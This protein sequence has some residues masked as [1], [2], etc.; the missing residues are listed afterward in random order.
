MRSTI[1]FLLS[2]PILF[3]CSGQDELSDSPGNPEEIPAGVSKVV[4]RSNAQASR[5]VYIFRKEGDEFRYNS[6]I[7]NGW[8]ADGQMTTRLLLGDYKFLFTLP[9]GEGL[10]V[11]PIPL[12]NTVT[13]EDLYFAAKA[14]PDNTQRILPVE[15]LF[16]PAPAVADSVYAIRGGDEIKCTL[17]RRVSQVEFV[18]KR[19]YKEGETYVSQP[20]ASGSNILDRVKGFEV[21]ISGVARECNYAKTSGKAKIQQ[22]YKADDKSDIDKDGFATFT[23]PFVFPPA[24]NSAINLNVTLV[25]ITGASYKPLSLKGKLEA[26]RKLIVTLWINPP[27]FDVKVTF[28]TEPITKRTDGDSGIWQ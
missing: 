17:T 3:S 26:N 9:S 16:L 7:D 2:L 20:Y 14:D 4:F 28:H 13:W 1:L 23:G 10:D 15:E 8:S 27:V 11:L 21:E 12:D 24:D 19:G 25:S 6:T 5:R 18:L 22:T